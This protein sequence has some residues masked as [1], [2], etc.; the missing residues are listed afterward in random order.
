MAGTVARNYI[1]RGF[2]QPPPL[3]PPTVQ[4]RRRAP[5]RGRGRG[6]APPPR[7]RAPRRAQ[8]SR[9]PATLGSGGMTSVRCRDTE[10]FA[11]ADTFTAIEFYPHNAHLP[12]LKAEA[13]KFTRYRINSVQISWVPACAST[14]TGD[15]RFGV[16]VGAAD[17]TFT[18][19]GIL[20]MR[21]MK[22]VA[23]WQPAT[24]T[25]KGAYVMLQNHLLVGKAGDN[26]SVAFTLYVDTA[27]KGGNWTVSYDVTF[28]YPKP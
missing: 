24:I 10:V 23:V 3:P 9:P 19:D 17:A 22:V 13:S 1:D 11:S 20:A 26:D 27:K 21:P 16:V 12:R 18:S 7:P 2:G 6:R 4:P 14:T 8:F 5:I 28:S 15:C 25:L